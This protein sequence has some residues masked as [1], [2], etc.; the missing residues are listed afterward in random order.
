MPWRRGLESQE[1]YS[2]ALNDM[3]IC[4]EMFFYAVVHHSVFSYR[5]YET[6]DYL[7]QNLTFRESLSHLLSFRDVT[8][9]VTDLA[10]HLTDKTIQGVTGGGSVGALGKISGTAKQPLL[11]SPSK[12]PGY[13]S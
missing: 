10:K 2:N 1:E 12:D 5:E 6:D 3:L 9:D 13:N 7:S 8:D 4:M 11:G